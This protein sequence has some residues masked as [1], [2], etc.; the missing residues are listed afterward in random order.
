MSRVYDGAHNVWLNVSTMEP[1]QQTPQQQN[2]EYDF[3]LNS[4]EPQKASSLPLPS[5]NS[6]I[7]RGL[8]VGACAIGLV[9]LVLIAVSNLRGDGGRRDALLNVVKIQQET[10][11]I[12]DAAASNVSS[13]SIKN[14]TIN[15]SVGVSSSQKRLTTLLLKNNVKFSEKELL[16]TTSAETDAKLDTAKAA[17]TYDATVLE[18]LKESITSY[19]DALTKAYDRTSRQELKQS[20]QEHYNTAK[21]LSEQLEKTQL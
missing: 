11:R 20:L 8:F 15:T 2:S 21:L 4:N 17:G 16:A 19:K 5:A 18:V 1:Q 10:V 3:I 7:K 14:A 9:L 13:Q 6:P 12:A